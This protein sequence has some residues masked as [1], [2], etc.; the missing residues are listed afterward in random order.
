[1]IAAKHQPYDPGAD[2]QAGVAVGH[3]DHARAGVAESDGEAL[4]AWV[5]APVPEARPSIG[6][7]EPQPKPHAIRASTEPAVGAS[8]TRSPDPVAGARRPASAG[9]G[10]SG[11]SRAGSCGGWTPHS[12]VR[13]GASRSER[14]PGHGRLPRPWPAPPSRSC[15]CPGAHW[16]EYGGPD[17]G[18]QWLAGHVLDA[19]LKVDVAFAR[20]AEAGAGAPPRAAAAGRL[21]ASSAS[22][23]CGTAPGAPSL[24]PPGHPPT[25]P[26]L[27]S[28]TRGVRRA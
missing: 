1:M 16:L 17:E 20:V 7:G 10:R 21:A 24:A 22:R 13:P 26:G 27:A 19:A 14:R 8:R 12:G 18:I 6:R 2:R 4:V 5:V 15:Y 28:R 3:D 9:P 11:R 25:E 23:W